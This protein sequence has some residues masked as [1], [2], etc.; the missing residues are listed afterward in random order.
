VFVSSSPQRLL[1]QVKPSF[2][3]NKQLRLSVSGG[4][5][6]LILNCI[7]R[8]RLVASFT[9]LS[10]ETSKR[11]TLVHRIESVMFLWPCIIS[12]TIQTTDKMPQVVR[13]LIFWNQPNMGRATNSPI[14]RSTFLTVYTYAVWNVHC[15]WTLPKFVIASAEYFFLYGKPRVQTESPNS[16]V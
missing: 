14:L 5:A 3:L 11:T 16:V 7:T 1:L 6:P 13:L 10:I 4:I 15:I 12:S 9:L 8:W 2:L